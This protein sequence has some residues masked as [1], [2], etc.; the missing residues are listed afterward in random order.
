MQGSGEHLTEFKE[1]SIEIKAA[2]L[3]D[4]FSGKKAIPEK[5]DRYRSWNKTKRT[6]ISINHYN[7]QLESQQ[8]E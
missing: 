7:Q 3:S 6:G 2:T 5:N 4:L 1:K 8:Y